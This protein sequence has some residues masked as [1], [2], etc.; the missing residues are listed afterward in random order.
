M[1][2]SGKLIA[3]DPDIPAEHQRVLI[4]VHGAQP[5]MHLMLNDRNLGAAKPQQ[6]WSP[7]PGTYHLMLEDGQGHA[8]S[9]V[10]FTVR[11]TQTSGE[12]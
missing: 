9:E 5:N 2:P 12:G 8:I 4:L 10:L 6:P 1:P 11:G 3:L 7:Q